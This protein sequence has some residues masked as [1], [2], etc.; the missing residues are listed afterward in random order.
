MARWVSILS[1]LWIIERLFIRRGTERE[2]LIIL[3][4]SRVERERGGLLVLF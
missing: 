4:D 1:K 3:D 2:C